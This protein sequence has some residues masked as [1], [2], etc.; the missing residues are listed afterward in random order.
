M[1]YISFKW[2]GNQMQVLFSFNL[3]KTQVSI[4]HCEAKYK[5]RSYLVEIHATNYKILSKLKK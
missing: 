1:Y 5:C 2:Y 3:L 4:R